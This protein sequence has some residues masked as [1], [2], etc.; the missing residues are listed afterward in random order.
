ML[1]FLDTHTRTHAMLAE[2]R[3]AKTA[4]SALVGN[5]DDAADGDVA[6]GEMLQTAMP[7]TEMPL[8]EMPLTEMPLT[9]ILLTE[10][11]LTEMPLTEIL[12]TEILLTE[13]RLL[14]ENKGGFR[15]QNHVGHRATR[16]KPALNRERSR[17]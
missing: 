1:G 16:A 5:E 14:T 11:L 7:L 8:T 15:T 17:R 9:E 4:E 12:L 3:Q 13:M 6:D 2:V 10:I